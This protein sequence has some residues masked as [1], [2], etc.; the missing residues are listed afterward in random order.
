MLWLQLTMKTKLKIIAKL[1]VL[2]PILVLQIGCSKKKNGGGGAVAN[3]GYYMNNGQCYTSN[4][5]PVSI[6]H[7]PNNGGLGG[8]GNNGGNNGYYMNNG[9]CFSVQNQEVAMTYCQ[10]T[11]GGTNGGFGGY[12]GFGGGG[13]GGFGGYGGF[14]GGGGFGGYGGFG[15]GGTSQCV[16]FYYLTTGYGFESVYCSGYSCSGYMLTNAYGQS[17]FCQ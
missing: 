6:N 15:G 1:V 4:G 13:G 7:C 14:G 8:Y 10:N 12:G 2:L 16:G 3:T 11:T 5:Q 9:R 17:I